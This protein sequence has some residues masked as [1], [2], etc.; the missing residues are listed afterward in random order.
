[1]EARI[2]PPPPGESGRVPE[3]VLDKVFPRLS[4]EHLNAIYEALM[5]LE[6]PQRWI[7]LEDLPAELTVNERGAFERLAEL[8]QEEAALEEHQALALLEDDSKGAPHWG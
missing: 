6:W 7:D 2:D 1:L 4:D 5:R 8:I 3:F